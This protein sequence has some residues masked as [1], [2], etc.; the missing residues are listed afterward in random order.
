MDSTMRIGK[1]RWTL[2]YRCYRCE[3]RHD[4]IST[5]KGKGRPCP[6]CRTINYPVQEVSWK[7]YFDRQLRAVHDFLFV[8]LT[9]AVVLPHQT[10][11]WLKK[12]FCWNALS[13]LSNKDQ[14][15]GKTLT[16]VH[17]FS[18]LFIWG[19]SSVPA[20]TPKNVFKKQNTTWCK[21]IVPCLHRKNGY[22][23]SFWRLKSK[24]NPKLNKLNRN[25]RLWHL[26]WRIIRLLQFDFQPSQKPKSMLDGINWRFLISFAVFDTECLHKLLQ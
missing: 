15:F 6:N 26:F 23:S 12:W 5:V 21:L 24:F 19:F 25:C 17:F 14:F 18:N 8:F 9:I 11:Q 7:N 10:W 13:K 4:A 22:E 20:L 1:Q 3:R 16:N 2:I